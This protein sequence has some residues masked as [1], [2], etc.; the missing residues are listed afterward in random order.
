M[1]NYDHNNTQ[2]SKMHKVFILPDCQHCENI[3]HE[4]QWGIIAFTC[5]FKTIHSNKLGIEQYS[6]TYGFKMAES[7]MIFI[8][9]CQGDSGLV[10]DYSDYFS[11]VWG[12]YEDSKHTQHMVFSGFI[13]VRLFKVVSSIPLT[14]I[15]SNN[16]IN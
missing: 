15:W 4:F 3:S 2:L 13:S 1:N 14:S 16:S 10:Y 9:K 5:C 8:L 6:Q 7:L 12:T 11:L